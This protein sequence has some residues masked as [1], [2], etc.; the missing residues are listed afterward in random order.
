M[1]DHM[2]MD[3][4]KGIPQADLADFASADT[5]TLEDQL[6]NLLQI[7]ERLKAVEDTAKE[8]AT[9]A[10][11]AERELLSTMAAQGLASFKACGFAATATERCFP[12]VRAAD[13]A[14]AIEWLRENGYGDMVQETFNA[15]SFAGMVRKDFIEAD[16]KGDV[17]EFVNLFSETKL[18]LRKAG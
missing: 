17:P 2:A 7:R 1:N 14:A 4:A 10:G 6:S 11:N 5:V 9:S 15:Q 18:S 8:L 13:R 12:S 16:R 3:P